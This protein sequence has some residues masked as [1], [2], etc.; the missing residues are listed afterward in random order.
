MTVTFGLGKQGQVFSLVKI[1][2]RYVGTLCES[3]E[4]RHEGRPTLAAAYLY[5]PTL[6][7]DFA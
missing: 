2:C 7:E 4:R 3:L 6:L 5:V 1:D